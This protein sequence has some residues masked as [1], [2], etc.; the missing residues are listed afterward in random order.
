MDKSLFQR[1]E[2]DAYLG[3]SVDD[4]DVEAIIEDA[5][6]VDYRTGRR[7][8][9]EGIDLAAICKTHDRLQVP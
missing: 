6:E 7:Y 8:W 3:E 5:T 2:L 4:F 1:Y 9:R